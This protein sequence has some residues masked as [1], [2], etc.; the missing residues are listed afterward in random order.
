MSARETFDRP[1]LRRSRRTL[2]QDAQ[3]GQ[4]SHPPNPC[5]YFTSPPE[6]VKI[7]SSPWDA[8]WPKQSRSE[9][10][11]VE[12]HTALRGGRSHFE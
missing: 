8:T 5:G 11:G 6:S 10:G 1:H 9:R 7:A 4:T 12:V 3:K 2:L